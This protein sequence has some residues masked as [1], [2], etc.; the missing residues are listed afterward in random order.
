VDMDAMK[1][2]HQDAGE[3]L[4]GAI[5]AAG[6]APDLGAP[7]DLMTSNAGVLSGYVQL[8]RHALD[9]FEGALRG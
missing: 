2:A 8:A 1:R 5:D 9:Q 7:A 6:A 3:F 4:Q